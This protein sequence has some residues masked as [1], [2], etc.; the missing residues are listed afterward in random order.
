[1]MSGPGSVVL[2]GPFVFF[3]R[4]GGGRFGD[5]IQ[6]AELGISTVAG[7]EKQSPNSE[8]LITRPTECPFDLPSHLFNDIH[9]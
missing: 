1:M 4:A 9:H 2:P 7:L 8:I 3:R 5:R 6:T